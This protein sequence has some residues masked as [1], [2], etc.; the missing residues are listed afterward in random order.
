MNKPFVVAFDDAEAEVKQCIPAGI[1]YSVIDPSDLDGQTIFKDSSLILVD[2]EFSPFHPDDLSLMAKDG[3][4]FVGHLR[5]WARRND[6]NLPP[7]VMFTN[8]LNAFEH[9]VPAVGPALPLGNFEG[10]EHRLAP[11]L[12]V[13]WIL[14]KAD[15]A[16]KRKVE[17]FVRGFE[18]VTQAAG[19]DGTSMKEIAAVLD[20]AR[21]TE[22][23]S[24]A[25]EDLTRARPPISQHGQKSDPARGPTQ[26][27]RWL[28]HRALPYPGL[29]LSD[30]HAAWAL[31]ISVSDL[32][33]IAGSISEEPMVGALRAAKYGGVLSDLVGR[34]WWRSGIDFVTSL[35]NAHPDGG[36]AALSNVLGRHFEADVSTRDSVVVWDVDFREVG[37]APVVDAVQVLARGWP[38]EAMDPWMRRSDIEGD[39]VFEA[40]LDPMDRKEVG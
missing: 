12:D 39:E 3:A 10:R 17:A 33:E 13:E 32:D 28:C 8:K 7:I 29:F 26:T 11:V 14:S 30:T 6:L 21:D 38:R 27:L 22:W 2:H 15:E 5:S 4:S 40:M 24:V 18:T 34:R 23:A 9:E 1:E 35:I 25:L 19:G 37:V 16:I 31:G 20:L 36:K